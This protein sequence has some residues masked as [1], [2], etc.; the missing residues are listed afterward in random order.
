MPESYQKH[1]KYH[2]VQL[3]SI[4]V[5]LIVKVLLNEK[6]VKKPEG[7]IFMGSKYNK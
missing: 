6:E 5:Y 4:F 2:L 1:W 3:I 7:I